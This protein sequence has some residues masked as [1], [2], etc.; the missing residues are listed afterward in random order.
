MG[1]ESV[2]TRD[3]DGL[4]EDVVRAFGRRKSSTDESERAGDGSAR[5]GWGGRGM[6]LFLIWS[7]VAGGEEE[8]E[9]GARVGDDVLDEGGNETGSK[10]RSGIGGLRS[11]LRV[12]RSRTNRRKVLRNCHDERSY[13]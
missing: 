13:I 5:S 8:G 4:T 3:V 12:I 11:G 10:S 6:W 9:D 2:R 1:D 7:G